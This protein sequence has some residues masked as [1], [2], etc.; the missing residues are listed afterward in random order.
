M[1]FFLGFFFGVAESD[2]IFVFSIV[3]PINQPVVL[4]Y[5]ENNVTTVA[6]ELS[7]NNHYLRVHK[8]DATSLT[9]SARASNNWVLPSSPSQLLV[10]SYNALHMM[11]W[12]VEDPNTGND[13]AYLRLFEWDTT[14][15]NPNDVTIMTSNG[16][17]HLALPVCPNNA[18]VSNLF[19]I[20]WPSDASAGTILRIVKIQHTIF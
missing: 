19:A 7:F 4:V 9:L 2:Q 16:N 11:G 17:N 18:T 13:R 14:A 12:I 15:A 5:E 20:P 8:Y 1:C 6:G 3:H 10:V